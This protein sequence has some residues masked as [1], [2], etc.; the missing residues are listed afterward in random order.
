MTATELREKVNKVEKT[1]DELYQTVEQVQAK[2]PKRNDELIVIK[3]ENISLE[4]R[5]SSLEDQ[6][7][8]QESYSRRHNLMFHGLQEVAWEDEAKF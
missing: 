5:I 1:T 7:L 6:L 4:R 3:Q 2:N 8:H